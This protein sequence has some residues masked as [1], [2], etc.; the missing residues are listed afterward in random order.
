MNVRE[1]KYADWFAMF[2]NGDIAHF[3]A[4]NQ[5]QKDTGE[6]MVQ[7]F[8]SSNDQDLIDK[9]DLKVGEEISERNG[10][11]EMHYPKSYVDFLKISS[12]ITRVVIALDLLGNQTDYSMKD[13][14]NRERIRLYE[15]ESRIMNIHS[16]QLVKKLDLAMNRTEEQLKKQKR[17]MDS[18]KDKK[19]NEDGIIPTQAPPS[20]FGGR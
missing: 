8:F 12:E 10:L 4:Y 11:I 16:H 5:Y 9:Y 7:F 6:F 13:M 15:K 20:A 14:A 2:G 1:Y 3:E 19:S 17:M 18:L